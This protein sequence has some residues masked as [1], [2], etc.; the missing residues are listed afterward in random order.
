[1]RIVELKYLCGSDSP[2]KWIEHVIF[3]SLEKRALKMSTDVFIGVALYSQYYDV[4]GKHR[5]LLIDNLFELYIRRKILNTPTRHVFSSMKRTLFGVEDSLYSK[6]YTSNGKDLRNG[7][8]LALLEGMMK[9]V[10]LEILRRYGLPFSYE[11]GTG[12]L[13]IYEEDPYSIECNRRE[14]VIAFSNVVMDRAPTDRVVDDRKRKILLTLIGM[15]RT[16][17]NIVSVGCRDWFSGDFRRVIKLVN[18]N[19]NLVGVA[20]L[21]SGMDFDKLLGGFRGQLRYLGIE[22]M[23]DDG[24]YNDYDDNY[25]DYEKIF[26]FIN[27]LENRIAIDATFREVSSVGS[28]IQT[29]L[30]SRKVKD[31]LKLQLLSPWSES[32]FNSLKSSLGN[33]KIHEL[34]LHNSR[35]SL[36]GFLLNED[37]RAFR[38]RVRVLE[39]SSV[40]SID[41]RITDADLAGLRIE[42]LC[43]NKRNK[44]GEEVMNLGQ[45]VDRDI[46]TGRHFKYLVFS[47]I[48]SKNGSEIVY[49]KNVS[50]IVDLRNMLGKR[51]WPVILTSFEPPGTAN[52]DYSRVCR[53]YLYELHVSSERN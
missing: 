8:E 41:G 47:S 33:P 46:I 11:S 9:M 38:D 15:V 44:G 20:E 21:D 22:F 34:E 2:R 31:I 35:M 50:E 28:T 24:N 43:I 12:N 17:K 4:T 32:E 25:N 5:D 27:S 40:G 14:S 42:R 39:V 10:L 3:Y 37:F 53:G 48:H 23:S 6:I 45:L 7:R 51:T 18:P 26:E 13:R 1:V 52:V 19:R 16:G 36:E 49:S 30:D 29:L